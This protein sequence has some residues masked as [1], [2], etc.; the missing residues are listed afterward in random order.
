MT[1]IV[2][3]KTGLVFKVDCS[4]NSLLR[5][6]VEAGIDI[7]NDLALIDCRNNTIEF[8]GNDNSFFNVLKGKL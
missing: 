6:T 8:E 3:R 2:N 4:I 7:D 1:K 5:S